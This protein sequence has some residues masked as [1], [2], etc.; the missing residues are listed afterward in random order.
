MKIQLTLSY[1]GRGAFCPPPLRFFIYYSQSNQREQ[2][3]LNLNLVTCSQ[4]I[5]DIF[6]W[7]NYFQLFYC[8]HVTAFLFTSA[9]PISGHFH[10]LMVLGQNCQK[11]QN[12]SLKLWFFCHF[13]YFCSFLVQNSVRGGG[14][15]GES[16]FSFRPIL[17]DFHEYTLNITSYHVSECELMATF[18]TEI[19]VSYI[20]QCTCQICLRNSKWKLVF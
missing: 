10:F 13:E 11:S 4:I 9:R 16:T 18:R 17:A 1:A 12:F 5:W 19:Y 15:G 6:W 3:L 14:G 8:F 20:S 7:N 2:R